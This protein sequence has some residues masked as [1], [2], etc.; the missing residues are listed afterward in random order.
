MLVELNAVKAG[1]DGRTVLA[2]DRF[3]VA[4]GEHTLILGPS[5]SGKTTLLNLIAGIALPQAGAVTVAGN[6]LSSM[7][8]SA[9]DRFRGRHIGLVMQR[10]HLISALTVAG[11]LELAQKLAGLPVDT[12]RIDT[13]L[14]ALDVT[15]RRNARPRQLSQGEAQ[16]VAIARAVL[17]RPELILADEPTAA[18]D[19]RNCA[20]ALD[21]LFQQVNQYGATLLVATHDQRIVP[22]FRHVL[23]LMTPNAGT[24]D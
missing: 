16:R 9:R 12:G 4:A 23:T 3:T 1:Y 15:F 7:G 13:T 22:R 14:A 10:L 21:L 18:L 11:N 17:N 8:E 5:G 19:D 6:P 2:L 20:A 24:M